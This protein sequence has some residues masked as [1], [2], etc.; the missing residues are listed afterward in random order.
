MRII[1]IDTSLRSTGVGIIETSGSSL[2]L[3]EAFAF[4][5]AADMRRSECLR[6]LN[7]ELSETLIRYAPQEA[8]LEGVFYCRN[9]KTALMLGEARGVVIAA[10]AGAGLPV[11]EYSP[12]RVK[13]A[14]VGYG[15]AG[16]EQVARMVIRILGLKE[17]PQEDAADALA[18]AICHAQARKTIAPLAPEPI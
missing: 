8:S 18:I 12:R 10:C 7:A 6:R 1:G 2:K 13:Q 16:K 17:L 9:A 11:F 3:V 5:Y 15:D 14:L 4:A